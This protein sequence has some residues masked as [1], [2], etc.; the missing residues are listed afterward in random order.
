MPGISIGHQR[1]HVDDV[2]CDGNEFVSFALRARK[3]RLAWYSKGCAM[4]DEVRDGDLISSLTVRTP[5]DPSRVL[6]QPTTAQDGKGLDIAPMKSVACNT[7][8]T[9]VTR[10]WY[11]GGAN[12]AWA[13]SL[14]TKGHTSR[15]A[16]AGKHHCPQWRAGGA[17]VGGE[18]VD[19][20]LGYAS[21]IFLGSR[22]HASGTVPYICRRTVSRCQR[23]GSQMP[24]R[25]R[26]MASLRGLGVR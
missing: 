13:L 18:A 24:A 14:S 11:G 9:T 4:L 26:V 6:R 17:S 1:Y 8:H 22:K 25:R 7:E 2:R 10:A 23:A 5:K 12:V 19:A 16:R 21:L 3:T 20:A 15:G